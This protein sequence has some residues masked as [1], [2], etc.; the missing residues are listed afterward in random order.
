MTRDITL[1]DSVATALREEKQDSETYNETVNRLLGGTESED[2]S[3]SEQLAQSA[4]NVSD[5]K[6][7]DDMGLSS[8]EYLAREYDV[9]A[10]Q[11]GT[12]DALRSAKGESR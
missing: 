6:R 4:M 3:E 9:D 10:E 2:V 11:Y 8:V 1:T 12:V 7:A 5:L